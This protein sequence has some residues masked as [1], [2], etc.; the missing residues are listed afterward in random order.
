MSLIVLELLVGLEPTTFR[1]Q[2][3]CSAIRS[4]S[5]E[6]LATNPSNRMLGR[7]NPLEVG[8]RLSAGE[9]IAVIGMV[10]DPLTQIP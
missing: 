1:L 5:S 7:Q 6:L 3:D 2:G 8:N 4:Y 10:F 9:T